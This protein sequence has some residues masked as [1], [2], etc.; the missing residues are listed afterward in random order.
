MAGRVRLAPLGAF[1]AWVALLWAAGT[2]FDPGS[3]AVTG[4]NSDSAITL[5][6]SNGGRFNLFDLY[7]WGQDRIGGWP[8]LLTRAVHRLFGFD[9]SA[10]RLFYVEAGWALGAFWPL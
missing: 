2:Q 9:W 3:M 6:M 1:L 7:Y 4:W 5:L 8:W 10:R